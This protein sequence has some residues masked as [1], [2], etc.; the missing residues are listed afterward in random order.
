MKIFQFLWGIVAVVLVVFMVLHVYEIKEY[1][2]DLTN[3]FEITEYQFD[4]YRNQVPMDE[5]DKTELNNAVGHAVAVG[6]LKVEFTLGKDIYYYAK[7]DKNSEVVYVLKKGDV[8]INLCTS[9]SHYSDERFCSF[10]TYERGWRYA[11][12]VLRGDSQNHDLVWNANSQ[13]EAYAYISLD[14]AKYLYTSCLNAYYEIMEE[15]GDIVTKE[16]RKNTSYVYL[17]DELL[18]D[19]GVYLSPD[20]YQSYWDTTLTLMT[21]AVIFCVLMIVAFGILKKK[22]NSKEKERRIV[23]HI[24]LSLVIIALFVPFAQMVLYNWGLRIQFNRIKKINETESVGYALKT[25]I[26][27][28]DLNELYNV[29]LYDRWVGDIPYTEIVLDRDV[30]YY[31]SDSTKSEI[32]YTL[33]AGVPLRIFG[34]NYGAM[35]A[36]YKSWPTYDKDWRYAMPIVSVDEYYEMT[37]DNSL[38]DEYDQYAYIKTEDMAYILDCYEEQLVIEETQEN[39]NTVDS[40]E[41]LLTLDQYLFEQGYYLS[42]N[43]FKSYR[44]ALLPK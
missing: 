5:M 9:H 25:P 41:I 11:L 32:L 30:Y 44:D 29:Y 42:K 19:R 21:C 31:A 16:Q 40:R 2:D 14:D 20:L 18:Y 35:N 37:K 34:L 15:I 22:I 24:V 38:Q 23:G 6:N 28:M 1:N 43:L 3:S 26:E 17:Y 13:E 12:P 27:E 10:P 4:G 7:P 36:R 39:Q 8:L 33:E